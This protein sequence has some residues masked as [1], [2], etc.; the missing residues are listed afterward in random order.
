MEFAKWF[1]E[2]GCHPVSSNIARAWETAGAALVRIRAWTRS[3]SRGSAAVGSAGLR[4]QVQPAAIAGA[5]FQ[6][7]ITSG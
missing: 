7:A 6:E 3:H 2:L 5:S 4:T 1:E